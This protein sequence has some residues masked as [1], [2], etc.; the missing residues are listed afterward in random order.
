MVSSGLPIPNGDRHFQEVAD[1]SLALLE[2]VQQVHVQHLDESL[3]VR[4]G[5]HSGSFMLCLFSL[6]A[7]LIG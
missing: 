7:S 1:L 3:Q 4:I 6:F 2:V 5:I